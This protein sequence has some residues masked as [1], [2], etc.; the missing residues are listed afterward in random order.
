MA[1][2]EE[3]QGEQDEQ[4]QR[5]QQERMKKIQEQA[6]RTM[7]SFVRV[8]KCPWITLSPKC[9]KEECNL[10]IDQG[11]MSQCIIKT[12]CYLMSSINTQQMQQT[13]MQEYLISQMERFMEIIAEVSPIS[14]QEGEEKDG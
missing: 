5:E 8:G 6:M 13:E 12:A 10:W 3:K 1:E 2:T 4:A 14:S 9:I 11:E 7:Q